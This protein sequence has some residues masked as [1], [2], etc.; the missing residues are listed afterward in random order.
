MTTPPRH[1]EPGDEL[2]RNTAEEAARQAKAAE[3]SIFDNPEPGSS[4]PSAQPVYE[5]SADPAVDEV[6]MA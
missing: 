1:A 2:F 4:V 6:M 3:G 5:V